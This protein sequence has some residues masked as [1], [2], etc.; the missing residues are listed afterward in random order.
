MKNSK[1]YAE[2]I[3]KLYRAL[4]GKGDK[5]RVLSFD[6]P[7]DSLVYGIVAERASS[8]RA[9]GAS[10]QFSRY[11]VD[12]NDIR[13][14][15]PEE[16]VEVFGKDT[17][18][19][20]LAA[21]TMIQVLGSI[22]EKQSDLTLEPLKK[23]GKRQA[24]QELEAIDGITHFAANFSMLTALQGHAIPLTKKMITYLKTNDLVCPEADDHDIEGFLTK[25]IAAK[26]G[27]PFY[28]LLRSESESPQINKHKAPKKKSTK[29]TGKKT[30]KKTSKKKTKKKTVKKTGKK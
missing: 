20:R 28:T 18:E 1:K 17:A 10:K 30:T 23:L 15:R 19:I 11:F 22:F 26:D 24:K 6:D 5:I 12:M 3:K 25:Q 4:K 29:K 21:N 8:S 2:R 13:V 9:R 27:F 7:I 14:A 16:I